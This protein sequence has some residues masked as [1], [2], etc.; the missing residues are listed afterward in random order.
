MFTSQHR[1]L[2]PRSTVRVFRCAVQ[3]KKLE[4]N[5]ES[6]RAYE[7]YATVIRAI[8]RTLMVT[9]VVRRCI[10]HCVY[11][12][13]HCTYDIQHYIHHPSAL[14]WT[15]HMDIHLHMDVPM[16]NSQL[17]CPFATTDTRSPPGTAYPSL[18]FRTALCRQALAATQVRSLPRATTATVAR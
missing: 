12:T 8:Q 14:K 5:V 17:S 6:G 11:T 9:P 2:L 7:L 18:Y 4:R 3:R 16:V 13:L 15:A 1:G 10:Q